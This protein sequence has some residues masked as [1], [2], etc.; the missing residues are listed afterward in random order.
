MYW[1]T[2]L[3]GITIFFSVLTVLGGFAFL[4]LLFLFISSKV[5]DT[6]EEPAKKVISTLFK[7]ITPIWL[8]A[9]IGALFIPTSK[10]MAMIYVVPQITESQ[11]VKQDIPE[12]YDLGVNALKDWLKQT[13]GGDNE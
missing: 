4:I 8:I 5:D 9:I 11:V 3:D 2:R 6:C 13:K 1:F 12:L 10:E 7:T